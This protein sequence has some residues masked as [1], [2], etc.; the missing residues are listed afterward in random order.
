MSVILV[1]SKIYYNIYNVDIQLFINKAY[2]D[3]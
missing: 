3:C 2:N 1:I